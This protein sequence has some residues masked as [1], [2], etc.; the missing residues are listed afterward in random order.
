MVNG[1]FTT[2][3]LTVVLG[4]C[5]TS[6]Y[7]PLDSQDIFSTEMAIETSS[8]VY[9]AQGY[10]APV[11]SSTKRTSTTWIKTDSNGNRTNLKKNTIDLTKPE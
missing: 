6:G 9:G 8:V 10:T 7:V 5:N 3:N 1:N 11:H 4:G 2:Q